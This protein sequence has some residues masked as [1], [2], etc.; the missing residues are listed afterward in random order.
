VQVILAGGPGEAKL[1]E[2]I[3][4]KARIHLLAAQVPISLPRLAAMAKLSSL[5]LC[6]DSGPMHVA[7]AVG[8]PIVALLGS[9]N[10]VV[11]QPVG[12][13]VLL[14][15]PMPCT[16]CI[17]P[18]QCVRTDSYRTLCVRRLDVNE[19]FEAVRSRLSLGP[20]NLG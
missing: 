10:T 5:M 14:S 9:Q 1:I 16:E 15:P 4:G 3:R 13:H 11:F 2:E 12:R 19:V 8:T 6:H 20:N 7:A 17:A 18:D